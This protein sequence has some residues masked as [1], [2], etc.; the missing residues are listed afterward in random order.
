MRS[1]AGN[2]TYL[3]P[4]SDS[5][6]SFIFFFY[7]NTNKYWR[8]VEIIKFNLVARLRKKKVLRTPEVVYTPLFQKLVR[9]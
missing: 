8:R 4:L 3:T 9:N 5:I 2:I 7:L 6:S 1:I